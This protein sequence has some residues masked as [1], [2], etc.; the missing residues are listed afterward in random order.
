MNPVVELLLIIFGCLVSFILGLVASRLMK[1]EDDDLKSNQ[2]REGL[3]AAIKHN[4]DLL[5]NLSEWV[6]NPGAT[7]FF[8]LDLAILNSTSSI[9]YE[10]LEDFS[11]CE[12]IDK[13][14]YELT[15]LTRKVDALFNLRFDPIFITQIH[16]E[17]RKRL[18]DSHTLLKESI[19]EQISGTQKLIEPLLGRLG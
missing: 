6:S 12:E 7:P 19:K 1:K 4:N 9:K 2:L 18:L 15:H 16:G 17:N 3:K 14:R 13:L 10:Y 11:L 8:N 5:A